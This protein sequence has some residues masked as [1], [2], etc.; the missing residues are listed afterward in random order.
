[1]LNK[2]LFKLK[3]LLRQ[4]LVVI[5]GLICWFVI[6]II[7]FYSW[8]GGNLTSALLYTFYFDEMPGYYGHFY[9][10]I[11]DFLI[12]SWILALI[13]MGLY[14]KYNPE[15]TCIALSKAMKGHTIIV[16]YNNLGKRI[17]TYLRQRKKKYV[18]IES[19]RKLVEN[20]I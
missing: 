11:S 17:R 18:I 3:I 1:M 6:H 19:N 14:R 8:T 10:F 16:G 4:N 7:L 5:I 9:P 12:F 20:L 15:Q 13:T 2:R